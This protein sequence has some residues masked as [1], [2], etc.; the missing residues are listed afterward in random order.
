MGSWELVKY[1]IKKK[2]LTYEQVSNRL[3]KSKN[4]ISST[5]S[6]KKSPSVRT[7]GM[8]LRAIGWHLE[9]VSDDGQERITLE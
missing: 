8:I 1:A 3:H 5:V 2:N 6:Q 9:A 4:Y 7:L